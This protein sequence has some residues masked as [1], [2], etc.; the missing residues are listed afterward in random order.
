MNSKKIT[1]FVDKIWEDSIVPQLVDYIRIPN[2]SPA[3][4]PQWQE[5]GHMEKA[6]KQI[7]G[8]CREQPIEGLAVEVQRASGEKC[9]RCWHYTEDVG[10]D[11]AWPSICARCARH[12]RAIAEPDRA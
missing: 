10:S 4:D 6:V 2:K 3:F 5:N 12:V 1:E 7:E 9:D 11:A 8:W